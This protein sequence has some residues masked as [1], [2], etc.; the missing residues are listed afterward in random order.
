MLAF[1]FSG[2][3]RVEAD[4]INFQVSSCASGCSNLLSPSIAATDFWCSDENDL[5]Q[6]VQ[7]DLGHLYHVTD[8]DIRL[9]L[10][11]ELSDMMFSLVASSGG[12]SAIT[13]RDVALSG[14]VCIHISEIH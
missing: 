8:I 14:A 1:C 9:A 12:E 7:L 5:E 4:G 3:D 13:Y 10:G 11:G 6:W 2:C